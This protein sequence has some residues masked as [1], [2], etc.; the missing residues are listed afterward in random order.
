MLVAGLGV[1]L[2]GAVYGRPPEALG[3]PEIVVALLGVALL[4]GSFLN[5]WLANRRPTD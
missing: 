4:F 3:A 1:L 2:L 5:D